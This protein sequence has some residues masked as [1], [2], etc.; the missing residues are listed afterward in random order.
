MLGD[1]LKQ[2]LAFGYILIHLH[3]NGNSFKDQQWDKPVIVRHNGKEFKIY[4]TVDKARQTWKVDLKESGTKLS[5]TDTEIEF[6]LP[7]IDEVRDVLSRISFANYCR[8][9]SIFTTDITFK[10]DSYQRKVTRQI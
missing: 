5:H 6:T 1:A 10:L 4:L 7:M 3:D 8:Q 2:I 9:Y